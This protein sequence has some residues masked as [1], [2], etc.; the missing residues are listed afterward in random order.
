MQSMRELY[1]TFGNLPTPTALEFTH[2]LASTDQAL[3]K[4]ADF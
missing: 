4:A 1:H 3:A 2:F